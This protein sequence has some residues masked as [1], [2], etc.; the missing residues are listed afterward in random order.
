MSKNVKIRKGA[1]L[2]LAGVADRVK[3]D[4]AKSSSFAIKPTD[5]HGLT[6]KMVVKEGA[7][8]KA[9]STLFHDKY[10]EHI[11][12]TS[13]VSGEVAAVVRGEKRK[14]L[15]VR[16]VPDSDQKFEDF[17]LKSAADMSGEDVKEALLKSGMWPFMKQ[18]PYDVVA[19][20]ESKPKAI[21]IS[22]FDSAPLGP[23]YDFILHGEAQAFQAGLD[24][25]SKLTEG[26][27]HLNLR[28]GNTSDET[29][30]NAKGVVKNT[31]SGPH[32]A[33]NVGVQIH[34]IDPINK[35]DV[36]WT[37]RPQAVAMIG[38]FLSTGKADFTKIVALA[39]SEVKK[40]HYIKTMVGASIKSITDGQ[41][42]DG[43]IRIISGNVLTG[44]QVNDEGYLGFYDDCVSVIPEGK[45]Y[46]FLGW[47]APNL[48]KLSLSHSYFSWLMPNKRYRLNTN[49]NGEE[50]AYVV[51][52]QYEDLLPMDIYPVHLIK[53]IMTNDI[54]RME[55]LGIYE[56]APED[57]ALCEFACTSKTDVQKI[58]REGLDTAQKELG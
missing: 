52:G 20:P 26:K 4:S 37:I 50:R 24:A 35:G 9:G 12:F 33:G 21:F 28:S 6:P 8:V 5:F 19:N 27:V 47:I 42:N 48:D 32:P 55:Q 22:A 34:H 36:V 31:F 57:M 46:Q 10:N 54:E 3:T 29:F 53:S 40:P 2:R 56:V 43:D 25:I 45:D 23:D 13:P 49:T 14:I 38:R 11:K 7:E 30:K 1:N 39:G 44:T 18:R 15:E 16:I 41:L 17:R 58:L 51:S